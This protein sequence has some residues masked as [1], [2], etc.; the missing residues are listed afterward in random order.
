MQNHNYDEFKQV[1][2]NAETI[3]IACHVNPDGDAIGSM[4]ALGLALEKSGRQVQ[5]VCQD[6]VPHPLQSL[7]G[8]GRVEREA[9]GA[10]DLA[11]AVDC[12]TKELLGSA[13]R[14]FET[15]GCTVEIDHH[16]YRRPFSL[17]SVIDKDAV[18]VGEMIYRMLNYMDM[19]I[20]Y[21][22]AVNILASI[23]VETMS[24]RGP[25]VN[26]ETFHMCHDLIKRGV[27]FPALAEKVYWTKSKE[28]AL[29]T[30]VSLSRCRFLKSGTIAWSIIREGDFQAVGGKDEDVDAVASEMLTIKG[31]KVAVFFREK[32]HENIFRV[33]LRSKGKI[34]ISALAVKYGGGGHCDTAGCLIKNDQ[35]AL[36]AFL[37]DVEALADERSPD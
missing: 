20:D 31:V 4:L 21:D 30:G 9:S 8:A 36:E 1:V 32:A 15:A 24:F 25:G 10:A 13:H 16:E 14:V 29:L 37:N 17:V 22:I 5:L 27:D 7:P 18:S 2:S 3:L 12:G 33:S 34:N 26:A 28:T 35:P 11:I 23:I 19:E 6:G